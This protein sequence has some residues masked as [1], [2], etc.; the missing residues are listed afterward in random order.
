MRTSAIKSETTSPAAVRGAA[1][2]LEAFAKLANV[3]AETSNSIP[4]DLAAEATAYAELGNAEVGG[5]DA[6]PLR[7]KLDAIRARKETSV[8][9]R[10]AAGEGLVQL[11]D[12]LS[13]VRRAAD[14]RRGA[15]AGDAVGELQREW[16]VTAGKLAEIYARA[17]LFQHIMH[18]SP[19]LPLPFRA[20]SDLVSGL[21]KLQF[22]TAADMPAVT[23]PP[24]L[25]ALTDLIAQ[26]D[27][28]AN[29]AGAIHASRDADSRHRRLCVERRTSAD[30]PGLYRVL[31]AFDHWG[32][33][34]GPGMLVDAS[35]VPISFLY[36]LQT[37][38]FISAVDRPAAIA[39]A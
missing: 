27:A 37:S 28:A 22:T 5:G 20:V 35:L 34:I 32:A 26:L 30:M 21:P 29:V 3:L 4:A 23:L 13:R 8:R 6:A 12:D 24:E 25:Q 18:V 14:E 33:K 9:R 31:K 7:A 38:R 10:A 17:Q 36:R 1:E 11:R 39:A 16:A 19:S 15:L 2:A